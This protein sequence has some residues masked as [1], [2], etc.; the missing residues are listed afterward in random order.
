MTKNCKRCAQPKPVDAFSRASSNKDGYANMCKPCV[1]ECNTLYWRTTAGR[2]SQIFAVQT[3]NSRARG[4]QPPA[5]TKTELEHWALEHGLVDLLTVWVDS[6]YAK[7]LIPSVDRLDDAKG[8]SLDN[9][10]L[11][12]WKDNNDKM[13]EHRK[14][15]RRITAQN[16][17]VEQIN[18][19][20]EVVAQFGSISFASRSTGITRININDVCR[21]KK[22][23]LTAGGFYWRYV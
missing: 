2:I 20:G 16:R 4:H 5:Y 12:T 1:V 14:D 9:I 11:G 18:L 19:N 23:C 17:K 8:Y 3:V 6:G 7:D 15:C 22:H 21:G 10:Q 13:Y